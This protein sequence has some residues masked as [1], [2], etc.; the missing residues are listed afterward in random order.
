M[1][2]FSL[3]IS[4]FTLNTTYCSQSSATPRIAMT[5][6]QR[7]RIVEVGPRDGLQNEK[8]IVPTAVKIEFIAK[9]A[10]SGLKTIECTR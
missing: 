4:F 10:S 8:A 3:N 6:P 1:Y 2:F 9:L 7:V 5:L